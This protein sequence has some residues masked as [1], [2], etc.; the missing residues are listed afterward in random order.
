VCSWKRVLGRIIPCFRSWP[1]GGGWAKTYRILGL[2]PRFSEM[3]GVSTTGD[4]GAD[5][6]VLL[7]GG[8]GGSSSVE[9]NGGEGGWS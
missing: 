6:A 3:V 4:I 5:E 7:L 1:A 8:A 2:W 9:G